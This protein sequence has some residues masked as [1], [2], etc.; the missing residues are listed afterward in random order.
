MRVLRLTHDRD[1]ALLAFLGDEADGRGFCFCAAWWVPTWEEWRTRTPELNRALRLS[2]LARGERDGY[3]LLD[4]ERV[5]GW[6]QCGPRDRLPKLV[7]Q[8]G[9]APDPEVWAFTCFEIAPSHR[10]RGAAALLL[11][12]AL[13]DLRARGVG[14]VQGFPKCG[15]DLEP[16][17][18]WTGPEAL[19]LSAGFAEVSRG[20]AGPV[21]E[22][23]P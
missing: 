23:R 21:V 7:A 1:A 20:P 22:R 9:L 10:G 14:R 19:F 8:Y 2:L 11:R 5:V 16:G 18:A 13:E 6:C 3:L 17:R 12:G 15:A 4:G